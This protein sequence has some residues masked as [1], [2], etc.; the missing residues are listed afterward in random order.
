MSSG[1]PVVDNG[2]NSA[3]HLVLSGKVQGVGFRPFVYR[4]AKQFRLTGWVRNRVGLVE[5]HAQ[6]DSSNLDRFITDLFLH[7]PPLAQPLLY[8]DSRVNAGAFDSFDILQSDD[9]GK[10]SISVPADLFTCD[11][12]VA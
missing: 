5:I 12:C 11:D 10:A 4:L 2:A 1:E 6:G 8:S 9:T 3:R 7:A